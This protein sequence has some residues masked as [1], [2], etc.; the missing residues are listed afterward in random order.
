MKFPAIFRLDVFLEETSER[1][2]TGTKNE[3][4]GILYGYKIYFTLYSYNSYKTQNYFVTKNLPK[5]SHL[6][7]IGIWIESDL[8]EEQF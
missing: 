5:N 8:R 7:L 1:R 3:I 6:Q 4:I 2:S